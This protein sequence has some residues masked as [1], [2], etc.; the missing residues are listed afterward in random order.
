MLISSSTATLCTFS[1][2]HIYMC[3]LQA[4]IT[5]SAVSIPSRLFSTAYSH[6]TRLIQS[7]LFA[8]KRKM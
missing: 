3:S 2:M 7:V 8:T 5:A 1:Q 4:F 6:F